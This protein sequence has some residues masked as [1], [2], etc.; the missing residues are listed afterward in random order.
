MARQYKTNVMYQLPRLSWDDYEQMICSICDQFEIEM[1]LVSCS[2]ASSDRV[3]HLTIRFDKVGDV[4]VDVITGKQLHHWE[5]IK[6]EKALE[7]LKVNDPSKTT[8]DRT[9]TI[10]KL[11]IV[12]ELS[13]QLDD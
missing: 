10:A 6:P 2:V 3:P 7:F 13:K 8:F 1:Y 11:K 12:K 4:I 5:G 9:D